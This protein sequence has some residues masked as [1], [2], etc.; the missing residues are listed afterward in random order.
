MDPT[1]KIIMHELEGYILCAIMSITWERANT[2][3]FPDF[4]SHVCAKKQKI[5]VAWAWC[6][7]SV[8]ETDQSQL[9]S[10]Y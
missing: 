1:P 3:L 4:V 9:Y 2:T 6:F 7:D 10:S 8:Q 5:S